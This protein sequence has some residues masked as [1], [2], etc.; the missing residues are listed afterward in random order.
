MV[1]QKFVDL[2]LKNLINKQA[3]H[4][5]QNSTKPQFTD[6]KIKLRPFFN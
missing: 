1:S 4:R 3:H 5:S 6:K 2:G